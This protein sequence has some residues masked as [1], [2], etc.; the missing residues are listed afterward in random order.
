MEMI[1]KEI[2]RIIDGKF[3]KE[4]LTYPRYLYPNTKIEI[5]PTYEDIIFTASTYVIHRDK[6][7]IVHYINIVESFVSSNTFKDK[8]AETIQIGLEKI[9]NRINEEVLLVLHFYKVNPIIQKKEKYVIE[10][11]VCGKSFGDKLSL[12]NHYDEEHN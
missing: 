4:I 5:C 10:C 1:S 8:E 3:V 7:D 11:K 12:Y 9:R 6:Q 2:T